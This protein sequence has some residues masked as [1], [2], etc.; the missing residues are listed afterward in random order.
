MN[1]AFLILIIFL[2]VCL[3]CFANSCFANNIIISEV[4]TSGETSKD[5]FVELYNQTDQDIDLENWSLKKQTESGKEYVLVSSSKFLGIIPGHGYFLITHPE[6][7]TDSVQPD[8]SYSSASYSIADTNKIILYNQDKQIIFESLAANL[9]QD[10]PTPQNS[11]TQDPPD[12]P[13]PPDTPNIIINEIAWMGT[14]DETYDEWIE[15]FNNSSSTV[16][17]DNWQFKITENILDL[18]GEI[19]PNNFLVIDAGSLNNSGEILELFDNNQNLIDSLDA[20]SG[21][22]GGDNETKQTLEKSGDSWQTSLEPGGTPG[23]P[24]SSGLSDT[25]PDPDPDPDP[26]PIIPSGGGGGGSPPK[27]NP[28]IAD[29]GSDQTILTNQ[30]IIFD[31]SNSSDP[32]KDELSFFWNL[33]NGQTSNQKKFSFS[34]NF[35]GEYL[36]TLI[37]SDS[38]LES[39]DAINIFVFSTGLIISEIN[40]ENNWVEIYNDSQ[41]ILNLENYALNN[42]VFPRGSLINPE[43]YLVINLENFE[44]SLKLIYP[45]N[46]IAQQ[47][48]FAEIKKDCSIN[49][50][51]QEEYFWSSIKTPGQPN[52]IKN[53]NNQIS[54]TKIIQAQ[55]SEIKKPKINYLMLPEIKEPIQKQEINFPVQSKITYETGWLTDSMGKFLLILSIAISFGL[56]GGH[57]LLKYTSKFR[58]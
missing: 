18:S 50:I 48:D 27:N 30:E 16:I 47:I 6:E 15:L 26:P 9:I 56:V 10:P 38:K 42:F 20:S 51:S 33:G 11:Q 35:P 14:L 21:W 8:L 49:R 57:L 24:N 46:Q 12:L 53:I 3:F 17:L 39:T 41:E 7:Y 45:N 22:P 54:N 31:A 5:E 43:Q 37:V 40:P 29:A 36:V 34:Y 52:Y 19:L 2:S 13:D 4:K 32:D 1:K 58:F 25:D 44:N 28:P 23:V 55:E